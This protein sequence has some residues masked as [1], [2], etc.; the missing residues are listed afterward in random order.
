MFVS[1]CCQ[2]CA[3]IG[4]EWFLLSVTA[5]EMYY[6]RG[7]KDMACG[8]T[9]FGPLISSWPTHQMQHPPETGPRHRAQGTVSTLEPVLHV[10]PMQDQ[11]KTLINMPNPASLAGSVQG[12]PWD[13]RHRQP[14]LKLVWD[15][16][17]M[18]CGSWSR[19]CVRRSCRPARAGTLVEEGC[20]GLALLGR[21]VQCRHMCNMSQALC[22]GLVQG[23]PLVVWVTPTSQIQDPPAPQP[24]LHAI[25]TPGWAVAG[26]ICSTVPKHFPWWLDLVCWQGRCVGLIWPPGP[27]LCCSS[28]AWT[29]VAS[30]GPDEFDCPVLRDALKEIADK[31]ITNE[32]KENIWGRSPAKP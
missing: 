19:C 32:K 30:M 23:M 26:A 22:T 18:Q 10:A 29:N 17:H 4:V 7:F 11:S 28:G 31:N 21:H 13:M 6:A 12:W 2:M 20:P 3:Y 15:R 14:S 27:A 16:H 9:L 24:V 5:L 1:Q 8:A 25:P